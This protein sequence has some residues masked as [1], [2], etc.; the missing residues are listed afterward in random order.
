[1]P[2]KAGV[3]PRDGKTAGPLPCC[4]PKAL[5]GDITLRSGLKG[6][7]LREV[8]MAL[9]PLKGVVFREKGVAAGPRDG[10]RDA[11][12][13]A[14]ADAEGGNGGS[15]PDQRKPSKRPDTRMSH[16][17][18]FTSAKVASIPC[19]CGLLRRYIA[20]SQSRGARSSL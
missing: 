16:S 9:R 20:L 18:S 1:M 12:G 10:P 2:L 19:S 5:S 13:E 6:V 4:C 3:W 14:N 11:M 15:A 8:D 17:A 7:W